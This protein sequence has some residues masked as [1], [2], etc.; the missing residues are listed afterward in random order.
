MTSSLEATNLDLLW[1]AAVAGY[2]ERLRLSPYA[3]AG[4]L[5]LI[6]GI[7]KAQKDRDG[8]R[9]EFVELF[10]SVTP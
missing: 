6:E 1:A 5:S 2:T 4:E 3:T 10:E 9:R 7:V 8:A